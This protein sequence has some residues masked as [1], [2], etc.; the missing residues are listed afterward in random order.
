MV[1]DFIIP[2]IKQEFSWYIS[3][4]DIEIKNTEELMN[5]L[6]SCGFTKKIL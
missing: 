1:I 5:K 3:S 2:E 6:K 4:E